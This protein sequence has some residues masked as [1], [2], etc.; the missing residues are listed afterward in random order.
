MG[1]IP[2]RPKKSLRTFRRPLS[3]DIACGNRVLCRGLGA[4]HRAANKKF[5]AALCV[6]RSEK[7]RIIL[8]LYQS[9]KNSLRHFA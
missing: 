5:P 3:G 9:D 6:E 4:A 2:L 1:A 8:N 7:K